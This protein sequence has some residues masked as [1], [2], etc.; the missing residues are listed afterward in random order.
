MNKSNKDRPTLDVGA[1]LFIS[2]LARDV[3]ED[4]IKT[5]FSLFG[6]LA[7][8]PIVGFVGKCINVKIARDPETNI[9]KGHAFVNYTSFESSDFVIESMNGQVGRD[10]H[11][12]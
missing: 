2:N 3:T 11:A 5:S 4:M 8:E 10:D 6:Q 12:R 9:S 7:C 1:D